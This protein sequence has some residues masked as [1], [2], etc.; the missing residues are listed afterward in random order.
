MP[1]ADNI[2]D[3]YII[4]SPLLNATFRS[5]YTS[6]VSHV[7]RSI[8]FSQ[9]LEG[10]A[11]LHEHGICHRDIK[12]DNILVRSYDPPEAMLTDLGVH[13]KGP[14]FCMTVQGLYPI[15]LLSRSRERCTA[16]PLITGGV[17]WSDWSLFWRKLLV[18][19]SWLVAVSLGTR[20]FCG[21]PNHH[22]TCVLWRCCRWILILG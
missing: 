8:F 18:R 13:R 21:L 5:L 11:F 7:G 19:G 4:I 9:L 6:N 20:N 1:T 16:A 3:E 12:P 14:K 15:L 22:R 10:V 17:G 2:T